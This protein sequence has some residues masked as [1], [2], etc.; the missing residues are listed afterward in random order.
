MKVYLSPS[1]QKANKYAYG[2]VSEADVCREIGKLVETFLIL[3]GVSCKLGLQDNYV[4]R[5][6]ESNTFYPDLHVC[7]HTNA[8]GGQ[9]TTVFTSSKCKNNKYA[10]SIYNEVALVTPTKDRGMKVKDN[11]YEIKNTR[12][13]CC[14]IEMEFHDNP[15]TAKWIIENKYE[16]AQS[17]VNGILKPNNIIPVFSEA[18]EYWR[19]QIGAYSK[20]E[21]ANRMLEMLKN[22]GVTA[23]VKYDGNYYRVQTGAYVKKANA[24]KMKKHLQELGFDAYI[25][26]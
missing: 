11:L 25:K 15:T 13:N 7:I 6:N 12:A 4:D 23:Y 20:K 24:E 3:N 17:I 1:S 19:V 22:A 10:K 18:K 8:G 2:G 14:Y 26:H 9:G 21:N 5:V 16:L